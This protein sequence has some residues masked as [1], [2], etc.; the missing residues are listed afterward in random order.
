MDE[1]VVPERK[2]PGPKVGRTPSKKALVEN[3]GSATK[4]EKSSGAGTPSSVT[5]KGSHTESPALKR[6]SS[7]TSTKKQDF[8]DLSLTQ[9]NGSDDED[10]FEP[11]G[12][13]GSRRYDYH[14]SSH[15]HDWRSVSEDQYQDGQVQPVKE[16]GSSTKS[17]SS[18]T[19]MPPR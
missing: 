6:Q 13:E 5:S 7:R 16:Q 9:Y 19:I 15:D 14:S 12:Q 17:N 8:D 18:K 2:K 10:L 3:P 1:P 4:P 11:R